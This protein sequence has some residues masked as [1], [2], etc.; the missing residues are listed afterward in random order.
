[1]HSLLCAFCCMRHTKTA[2]SR[3]I[4]RRVYIHDTAAVNTTMIWVQYVTKNTD[5]CK[6]QQFDSG[7]LSIEL[8][9]T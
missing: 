3:I 1:M 9:K 7:G 8:G 6:F 2:Y 4:Y 5:H